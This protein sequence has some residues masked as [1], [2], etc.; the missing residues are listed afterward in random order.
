MSKSKKTVPARIVSRPVSRLSRFIIIGALVIGLPVVATVIV[1]GTFW[2]NDSLDAQKF[3]NL[4]SGLKDL[5]V[6]LNEGQQ[7]GL[8]WDYSEACVIGN[9]A[10][11][12]GTITCGAGIEAIAG[13]MN[14][15]R[16]VD[17]I[18]EDN[19]SA[20]LSDKNISINKSEVAN[21]KG[22][23]LGEVTAERDAATGLY[24]KEKKS[25]MKCALNH[26]LS[27]EDDATVLKLSVDCS[28]LS[29][30]LFY[31]LLDQ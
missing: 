25:N 4:R 11:G 1:V 6:Y 10:F 7:G 20:L 27:K 28:A 2:I 29:N 18:V 17:G 12:R 30:K 9:A 5:Q 16:K 15:Q 19:I 3:S 24:L 13:T 8:R 26:V 14:S 31:K 22:P 23:R 21:Y